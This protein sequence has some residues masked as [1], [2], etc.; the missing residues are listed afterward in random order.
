MEYRYCE[1]RSWEDFSSGR[2][3]RGAGGLRIFR[4]V[5]DASC[6]AGRFPIVKKRK[7]S[8]CTTAAAEAAIC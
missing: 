2:V 4:S 7:R 3:L 5:W 1:D 6:T 8:G